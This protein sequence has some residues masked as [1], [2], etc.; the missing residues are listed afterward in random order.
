[1]NRIQGVV[2]FLLIMLV[3]G[4]AGWAAYRLYLL[5]QQELRAE[6]NSTRQTAADV[7][8][9]P[10]PVE[11]QYQAVAQQAATAQPDAAR[12][13]WMQFIQAHPDSPRV[14]GAEAAVGP[15][16]VV[17]LFSPEP[18]EHKKAYTVA[19]GDSLYKIAKQHGVSIELLARAN[20]LPNTM[21]QIGQPLIVPEMEI[22]ATIDRP[23]MTLRLNNRG[24][25]LRAYPL[26]VAAL[27]GAPAGA[28]ARVTDAVVEVDGKRVTFGQ[29]GYGEGSRRI[30]LS[31]PG[32][33]IVG[34]AEGTAAALL[35]PG[36]V[37]R[38]TD[39]AEI[40]VLLRS[41]VPVTIK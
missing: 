9:A 36:V 32:A 10:D 7:A 14:A 39:L 18:A 1:M 3:L 22:T 31:A 8:A 12:T 4:G 13:M 11:V 15:L 28:T 6:Q 24:E 34:A 17:A 33:P 40:F 37:V 41:G 25:F 35:P 19:K 2:V 27:P 23:A 16:N 38:D 30:L 5:P 20:N 29:K 21:L 26:L